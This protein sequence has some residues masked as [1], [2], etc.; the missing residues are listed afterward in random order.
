M[1]SVFEKLRP[2]EYEGR[3]PKDFTHNSVAWAM[4]MK[5]T[6]W[7][8]ATIGGYRWPKRLPREK[9]GQETL[10]NFIRA[11]K[12]L[13]YKVC[14]NKNCSLE[15]GVEKV[16]I[17]VKGNQN[18]THVARQL[19]SG[20]W[21]SK[22]GDE[23]DIEHISPFVLEGASYGKVAVVMKRSASRFYERQK[24]SISQ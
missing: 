21:T 18:P 15:E 14:P 22:I 11:F 10:A 20:I 24:T 19:P 9:P 23:E 3:S 7:W 6:R 2:S 5:D 17:Y 1:E 12:R 4:G 13:R 8:P 16:A